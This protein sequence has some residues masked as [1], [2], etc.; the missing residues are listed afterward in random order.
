VF[1]KTTRTSFWRFFRRTALKFLKIREYSFKI[2][3][4]AAKK[5]LRNPHTGIFQTRPR[6]KKIINILKRNK[7]SAI[8]R[9]FI[10]C[11]IL[12]IFVQLNQTAA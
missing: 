11:S 9:R 10:L 1:E 4:C 3:S 8:C 12:R 5:S 2:L 7:P 6:T